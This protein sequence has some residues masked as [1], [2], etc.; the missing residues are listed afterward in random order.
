MVLT[1][2]F[3]SIIACS[4]F[5]VFIGIW[6]WWRSKMSALN[7]I[8][9]LMSIS[10]SG[11]LLGFYNIF[12]KCGISDRG[13]AFWGKLAYFSFIPFFVLFYHFVSV[14]TGRQKKQK[15]IIFGGYV[16]SLVFMGLVWSNLFTREIFYYRWG[17]APIAYIGYDL[18]MLTS[19]IYF[20]LSLYNLRDLIFNEANLDKRQPWL[21]LGILFFL[22][23]SV[24]GLLSSYQ[25]EM[26]PILFDGWWLVVFFSAYAVIRHRKLNIKVVAV[27]ILLIIIL[28]VF[29]TQMIATKSFKGLIEKI[30]FFIIILVLGQSVVRSVELESRQKDILEKAVK[31]RTKEL[32]K[33]YNLI[34]KRKDDLEHF[35]KLT[36][37]R[38][39]KM[40]EL[41]KKIKKLEYELEKER[42]A[43]RKRAK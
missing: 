12:G 14:L 30:F 34:K 35:Y 20:I 25:I 4:I 42:E 6:I 38:E 23:L 19:I 10:L 3:Y 24:V 26:Y 8:F 33:S 22:G 40:I 11:L 21:I 32:E 15:K 43:N 13:V 1:I 37:G 2:I 7:I 36:V 41:K 27:E 31:E 18:W 17:C 29:L 28:V 39:L 5:S 16:V 9:L